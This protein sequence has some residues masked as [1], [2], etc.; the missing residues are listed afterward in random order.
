MNLD[1]CQVKNGGCDANAACSHDRKTNEVVCTC[2]TGYTNTS[3]TSTV[4]CTGTSK[5]EI[6]IESYLQ[7]CCCFFSKMFVDSCQVENGG[8]DTNAICSHDSK[9]NAV[10]CTCKTGYTNTGSSSN[11]ICKGE[12]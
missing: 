10:K 9:T 12:N 1:S 2:K 5:I 11:V 6:V 8:C 7:C 4:V 3:P